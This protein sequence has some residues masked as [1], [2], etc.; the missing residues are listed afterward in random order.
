MPIGVVFERPS[1]DHN[2]E[3]GLST[4]ILNGLKLRQP[5]LFTWHQGQPEVTGQGFS[6]FLL[7]FSRQ[8]AAQEWQHYPIPS[9]VAKYV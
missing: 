5:R 6:G 9:I 8:Q 4:C 2:R 1:E 7:G 3:I